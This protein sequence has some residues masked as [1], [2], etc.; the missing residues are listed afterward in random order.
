MNDNEKRA[1]DLALLY[2]Q[3]EIKEGLIFTT[4]DDDFRDFVNEYEHCYTEFFNHFEEQ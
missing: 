4:L 3:M 1:H 2:M